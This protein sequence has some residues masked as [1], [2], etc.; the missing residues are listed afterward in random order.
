MISYAK[1]VFIAVNA[2]WRWLNNF[3]CLFLPFPLI[4]KEKE[5]NNWAL[6]KVNWL[7]ACIALKFCFCTFPPALACSLHSPPANGKQ[8]PIP[9]EISKNPSD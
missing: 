8:G 5:K 2:S 3:S 4:T 6:I 1:S 9:E 7:A